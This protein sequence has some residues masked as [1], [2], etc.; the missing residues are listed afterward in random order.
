MSRTCDNDA[1]AGVRTRWRQASCGMCHG[2]AERC[3]SR[4][5]PTTSRPVARDNVSPWNI[6]GPEPRQSY[7]KTPANLPYEKRG[8]LRSPSGDA[9]GDLAALRQRSP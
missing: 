4:D 2:A 6:H 7:Q 8:S 3:G 1:E 5:A 9:V